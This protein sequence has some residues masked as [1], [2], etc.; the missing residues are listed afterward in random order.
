TQKKLA[1]DFD[2]AS[3]EIYAGVHTE[4]RLIRQRAGLLISAAAAP[5]Q[6]APPATELDRV[7]DCA[8]FAERFRGSEEFVKTA[9]RF[10]IPHFAGCKEVLDI[11]C[12][13]G[14]F[15]ELMRD[16]GIP[17]RGIDLSRES[18]DLC[19]AKGLKADDADL[20]AYLAAQ[21]DAS[22]DGIFCAQVVEHLAPVQIP[23]MIRLT[24]RALRRGG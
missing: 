18:V 1:A 20:F 15:L 8:H 9:Q 23:E 10:Y 13:R 14:E 19:R 17:A 7:F 21:P 3:A 5:A 6:P 22:F 2:Q 4:V 11:G 12:G 16:A 24:A